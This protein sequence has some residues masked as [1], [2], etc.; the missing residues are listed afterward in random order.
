MAET[1]RSRGKELESLEMVFCGLFVRVLGKV[2]DR[3]H[4]EETAGKADQGGKDHEEGN[5]P[6]C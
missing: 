5:L 2:K 6:D 3:R 4:E 1:V